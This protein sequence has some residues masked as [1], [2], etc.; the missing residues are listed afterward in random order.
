MLQL[1]ELPVPDHRVQNKIICP[2]CEQSALLM[3]SEEYYGQD[4][5][6]NLYVCRP[7]DARVGTHKNSTKP[8]GT[9]ANSKLRD[10]RMKCHGSFDRIWKSKEMTRSK[11]YRWLQQQMGL[12]SQEAHIGMFNEQQ[13]RKLLG[14]LQVKRINDLKAKAKQYQTN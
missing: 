8:L 10:L 6:T 7:C 11:A 13:C 9:L 12:S 4:Y 3:T 2:Y 5:G 14:I 1:Q